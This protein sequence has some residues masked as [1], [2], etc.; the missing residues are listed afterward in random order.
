MAG[1]SWQCQDSI[2]VNYVL[3]APLQIKGTIT[4]SFFFF[5]FGQLLNL[6][7]LINLLFYF[8][9]LSSSFY[10]RALNLIKIFILRGFA[11]VMS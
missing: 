11:D 8:P 10:L 2:K 6:N 4:S 1:K 3:Y 7:I 9:F 5:F